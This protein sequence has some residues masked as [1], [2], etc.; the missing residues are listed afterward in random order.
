LQNW[1]RKNAILNL[2]VSNKQ[3]PS[4]MSKRKSVV[5]L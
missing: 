3:K 1:C 4:M 2:H 5:L